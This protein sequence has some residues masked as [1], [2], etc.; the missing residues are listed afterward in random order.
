MSQHHLFCSYKWNDI[1]SVKT[2]NPFLLGPLG[3]EKECIYWV[4]TYINNWVH[5]I[6]L[7]GV[8][9]IFRQVR[10]IP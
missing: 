1:P 2:T 7:I 9:V 10:S 8:T 4:Q 3:S 6:F 5:M